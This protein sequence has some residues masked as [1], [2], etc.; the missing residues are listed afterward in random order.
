VI[1]SIFASHLRLNVWVNIMNFLWVREERW[2]VPWSTVARAP[3]LLF[4]FP[5]NLDLANYFLPPWMLSPL[6]LT[7]CQRF[8]Q[9]SKCVQGVRNIM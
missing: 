5:I 2:R 1:C 7:W 6:F 3:Y 8:R 9:P 4:V